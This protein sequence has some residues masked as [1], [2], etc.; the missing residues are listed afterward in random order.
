[1]DLMYSGLTGVA[2]LL[3]RTG[4]TGATGPPGTKGSTGATGSTG[5]KGSIGNVPT[6]LQSAL[7]TIIVYKNKMY[8]HKFQMME[9]LS[10]HGIHGFKKRFL[11]YD[12]KT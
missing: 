10:L 5:M 8:S 3:G 9:S 7:S 1:M 2:G 4:T 11:Y 12:R 6:N